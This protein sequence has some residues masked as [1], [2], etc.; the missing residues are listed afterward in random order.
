MANLIARVA[1]TMDVGFFDADDYYQ[2]KVARVEKEHA[3]EII[4]MRQKFEKL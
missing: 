3:K 4:L 1:C 2:D